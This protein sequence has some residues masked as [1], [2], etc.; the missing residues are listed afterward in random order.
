MCYYINIYIYIYIYIY[1][2]IS[3]TPRT[4]PETETSNIYTVR[5]DIWIIVF[6]S[7]A[8]GFFSS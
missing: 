1:K 2:I 5:R 4:K 7:L 6:N 8:M 3:D